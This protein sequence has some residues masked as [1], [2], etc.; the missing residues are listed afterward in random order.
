[1]K[2][3]PRQGIIV[4]KV[5]HYIHYWL[6]IVS[7]TFRISPATIQR[8]KHE[9]TWKFIYELFWSMGTVFFKI[10]ARKT[11]VN[12]INFLWVLISNKNIFE[13]QVIVNIAQ[14][15][16]NLYSLDQLYCYHEY[17]HFAKMLIRRLFQQFSEIRSKRFHE[18]FWLILTF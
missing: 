9:I 12:Q 11:K 13:F 10:S 18:N 1:M 5:N 15:M 2:F 14:F 16:Q 6:D 8:R 17:C 7:S 4:Q 3:V